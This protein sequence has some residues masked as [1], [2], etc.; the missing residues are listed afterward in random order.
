MKNDY[1]D[2]LLTDRGKKDLSDAIYCKKSWIEKQNEVTYNTKNL[3]KQL[4]PKFI[5]EKAKKN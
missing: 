2:Y 3:K 4:L 1:R 5:Q